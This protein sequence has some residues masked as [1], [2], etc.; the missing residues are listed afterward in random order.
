MSYAYFGK[1]N[2]CKMSDVYFPTLKRFWKFLDNWKLNTLSS[3][4]MMSRMHF[5][6]TRI[7]AMKLECIS[8]FLLLFAAGMVKPLS[9]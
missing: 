6:T 9:V 4:Y 7:N 5:E 2:F 1:Q 8:S 3:L